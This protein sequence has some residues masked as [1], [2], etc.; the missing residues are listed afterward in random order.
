MKQTLFLKMGSQDQLG[1]LLTLQPPCCIAMSLPKSLEAISGISIL[2]LKRMVLN[3]FSLPSLS[4]AS[5]VAQE[6]MISMMVMGL[7]QIITYP[8]W[9]SGHMPDLIFLL[10]QDSWWGI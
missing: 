10:E 1:L 9:N 2:F 6:F 5:E 4:L 7:P 3:D 8:I